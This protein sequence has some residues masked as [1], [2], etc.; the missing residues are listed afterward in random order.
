M[1]FQHLKGEKV[2][3]RPLLFLP[4]IFL[5]ELL[6]FEAMAVGVSAILAAAIFA[7]WYTFIWLFSFLASPAWYHDHL[8]SLK[9]AYLA[10]A[11]RTFTF[12]LAIGVVCAILQTYETLSKMLGKG[13]VPI[14]H[15]NAILRVFK[16]AAER[17]AK[18]AGKTVDAMELHRP[19]EGHKK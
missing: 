17:N 1:V 7:F 10:G 6:K 15:R 14:G 5:K 11:L 8:N 4:L 3:S 19:S 13:E 16:D 12:C 9:T 2:K 18:E